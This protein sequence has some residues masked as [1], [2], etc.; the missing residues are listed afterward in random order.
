MDELTR[1]TFLRSSAAGAAILTTPGLLGC[2]RTPGSNQ[3]VN[4]PPG[5]AGAVPP[6]KA[7]MPPSEQ[8]ALTWF[9]V[10]KST[11]SRALSELSSRGADAADLYAYLM[12]LPP[13]EQA[14][15]EHELPWYFR[16]RLA[17][18]FWKLLFF[19][20]EPFEASTTFSAVSCPP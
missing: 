15:R 5:Q 9:N 12:S 11:L 7:P 4:G 14:N 1:R 20:P 8:Q 13:V 6:V 19:D 3:P 2:A 18:W 16:W 17:N 10:D